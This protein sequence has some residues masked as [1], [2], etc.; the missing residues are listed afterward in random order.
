MVS[1]TGASNGVQ[2]GVA[3][4]LTDPRQ[5]LDG[6]I[7]DADAVSQRNDPKAKKKKAEQKEEA[8]VNKR[9]SHYEKARKF[10]EPFRKQ[11][12]L[13]RKYAAGTSDLSWAV[14]TNLIGA[15]IDILT[16]LLYARDPDVSATKAAQVDDAGTEQMDAFAK[17]LQIVI[18]HLWRKGKLKKS[19][20]KAVRSVLS[21]SEGW[22]KCMMISE[23]VPQPEVETKLNDARETLKRLQA[24]K[25]L[26][27]DNTFESE[28]DLDAA[29]DE[30]KEL[31]EALE[32]DLELAVNRMFVID[33]VSTELMQVSTDVTTISDYLD[34]DWIGNEMYLTRE[35]A[36]ERFGGESGRLKPE[37]LKQ[38]KQYFQTAPME[39]TNR[40]TN[41]ALPQGIL[42]AESAQ[43]FTESP[44]EGESQAFLRVIEMWDRRDKHVYTMIDGVK[45]WAKEPFEPP[46]PTSRFYPYFYFSFYEVDGSRHPQSLAWRLYKL[47]DEYSAS[48]SNFR[49]ARERALPNVL[50]NSTM[51]DDEQAARISKSKLQ[52]FVPVTPADPDTPLANCFTAK[53]VSAID[54]RLYDP[55]LI[56]NDMERVSGVQEALSS[57]INQKGNPK[58]ATE[59]NIEQSGT[60]ART[61]SDRDQLEWCLTDMAQYTAEQSIQCLST[62]EVQRI[63]GSKA[64]WAEGMSIEDLFTMAEVSIQAGTT[65]KPRAQQD[66]QAWA[67]ILPLIREMIQQIEQALAVGNEPLANSYIELIKETMVRMGD[68]SDVDRFVPRT[69]PPGSPGA[70]APPP[71]QKPQVSISLRGEIPPQTAA[72]LAAPDLPA[73]PP[74]PAPGAG[75]SVSP[76]STGAPPTPWRGSLSPTNDRTITWQSQQ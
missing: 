12:A 57:A 28:E 53:P 31:I 29:L 20:R 45:K 6:G 71:Q 2:G 33:Y 11:V 76:P 9:W 10:D 24:Q 66:Q 39:L 27:E 69:P 42:T 8:L 70:G 50:F 54:M 63:A 43:A 65:G 60:N 37:D 47:Q 49:I 16:A 25:Q 3:G 56:L 48:R 21:N 67:T 19:A 18:S 62:R 72:A 52:E 32:G 38:A 4:V 46:Y 30:K 36:L 44:T 40:E 58:T 7:N 74:I 15:F 73:P 26:L 1:N 61:T 23:K 13:D 22:F 34:A 51:I 5:A 35:E 17:T 75:A 55:T 59:A 68:E 14:T 64:F 41:N